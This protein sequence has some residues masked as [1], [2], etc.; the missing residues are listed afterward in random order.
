MTESSRWD[1]AELWR[2]VSRRDG[3]DADPYPTL[4]WLRSE[5]PVSKVPGPDGVGDVW[6]VTPTT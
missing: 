4:A 5:A 1:F 6:F 3:G 2:A